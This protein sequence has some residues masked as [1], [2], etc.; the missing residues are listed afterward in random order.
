MINLSAFCAFLDLAGC[1]PLTVAA[2]QGDVRRFLAFMDENRL[3]LTGT[4]GDLTPLRAYLA[5]LA[6][7]P[8]ATIGRYVYAIRRYIDYLVAEGI[9][10]T[11][12]ADLLLIPKV[13]PRLPRNLQPEVIETAIDNA[14]IRDRAIIEMLYGSGLRREEIC[15]V[16]LPDIRGGFVRVTGKG[17]KVRE[18][19]LTR[20]ANEAIADWMII[21]PQSPLD[22]L[23][24]TKHGQP[25][26]GQTIYKIIRKYIPDA[27]P[28]QMRHSFATELVKAGANIRAVQDMMGHESVRTTQAYTHLDVKHLQ[29]VYNKSFPRA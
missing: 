17:D 21:R 9:L 25:L 6:G 7:H 8:A 19:P 20:A 4:R 1:A 10:G 22:F 13:H 15:G 16:Q 23:F 24:L 18:V 2:Y 26:A 29:E 3:S 27:H 12:A 5:T 28:H 11:N 14:T